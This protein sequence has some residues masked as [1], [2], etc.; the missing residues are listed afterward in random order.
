MC[1]KCG[2]NELFAENGEII[3]SFAEVAYAFYSLMAAGTEALLHML[4][5][6][7]TDTEREACEKMLDIINGPLSEANEII[8]PQVKEQLILMNGGEP[9]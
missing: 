6:A 1:D 4:E 8:M 3:I 2:D 5:R 7:V 9:E